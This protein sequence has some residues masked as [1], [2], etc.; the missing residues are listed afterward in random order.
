MTSIQK[1]KQLLRSEES[2]PRPRR[3]YQAWPKQNQSQNNKCAKC[4]YKHTA[5][6][7]PVHCH[8]PCHCVTPQKRPRCAN[9]TMPLRTLRHTKFSVSCHTYVKIKTISDITNGTAPRNKSRADDLLRG[10]KLM[11]SM[12][13]REALDNTRHSPN[14][15]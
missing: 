3:L 7:E 15:S 1:P 6:L 5:K 13:T 10:E 14:I 8:E 12:H 4:N 9:D 2:P 11:A